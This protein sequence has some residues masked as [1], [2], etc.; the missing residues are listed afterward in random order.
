[1]DQ[2]NTPQKNTEN[3]LTGFDSVSSVENKQSGQFNPTPMF[4]NLNTNQPKSGYTVTPNGNFY[5]SANQ[6]SEQPK[7]PAPPVAPTTPPVTPS[8]P[9]NSATP[10]VEVPNNQP[11]PAAEPVKPTQPEV[12]KPTSPTQNFI[13]NGTYSY[14]APKPP[15]TSVTPPVVKPILNQSN[16]QFFGDNPVSDK[17]DNGQNANPK[18][19]KR[20]GAG[21]IILSAV[22]AAI[23]G[24]GGA[25]GIILLA[26][27]LSIG[28]IFISNPGGSSSQITLN[29]N[30]SDKVTIKENTADPN[31]ETNIIV[32]DVNASTIIEAAAMKAGPS[33]V[34]I[35]TTAYITSFFGSGEQTTGEGSGII[36]TADGYIITNYHVIEDAATSQNVNIEVYLSSSP[37]TAISATIIGY[38]ASSDLAV[39]KIEKNGLQ[40]VEF[41]N[42]DEVKVGQYAIAIGNPG[43]IEFMG[44]VSSGIISG[45][46]RSISME[47]GSTMGLIQTDAAINPGNSGG[48]LVN[49]KGQLIGVNTIKLISEGYES[50]GFAIP[51]NTVKE[52]CNNI[53]AKQ[54]DPTPYIGLQFSK[55]YSAEQLKALG[56]P[57]GAVVSGVIDGS[58]ANISGI[59]AGDIITSFN[60]V[61]I[62]NYTDLEAEI[63]KCAPGDTVSVKLYRSGKY[64]ATTL[65]VKSNNAQ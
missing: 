19:K 7:P 4:A 13:P 34:G 25:F 45:L 14:S 40:P 24:V 50:M 9:V 3:N 57:A 29:T 12:V 11:A 62:S 18:S 46:N 42:S 58:P 63:S 33:V 64:F 27:P 32:N 5:S 28:D 8:V 44:S 49:N 17:T 30:G 61:T 16:E 43:G 1:M 37:S 10:K 21:V 36:Y 51:S 6:T 35:R 20:Y 15:A 56:Y 41:A 23:I 60:G 31:S 39:I 53:I 22:L 48:A 65:T 52:I 59:R 55:L 54:N 26:S 47:N 38:N 2:N